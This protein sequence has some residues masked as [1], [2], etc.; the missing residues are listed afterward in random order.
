MPV[1]KG[2]NS[3]LIKKHTKCR[4]WDLFIIKGMN[5]ILE[6]SGVIFSCIML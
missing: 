1:S 5:I 3:K 4:E 6:G 2:N